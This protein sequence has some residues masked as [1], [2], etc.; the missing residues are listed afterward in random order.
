MLTR[1]PKQSLSNFEQ[2]KAARALAELV[3]RRNEGLRLY[4]SLPP[5]ERF[6]KS[7]AKIRM[8]IASN[9]GGKTVGAAA[10]V[11]RAFTATDPYNK[12]PKENGRAIIVAATQKKIADPLWLKL[13]RPGAFYI[14]RDE[15]TRN[16]RTWNPEN[17]YDA[18]YAEK[19]KEAAPLIPKRLI[20]NISYYSVKDDIPRHVVF[21]TGWEVFF[22]ADSAEPER[23]STY[24][25]G[26][27]DEEIS[28]R[29]WITEILRGLTDANGLFIWSA[30][31]QKGNVHAFE[32]YNRF[33]EGDP[34]VEVFEFFLRDNPYISAEGKREFEAS[35]STEEERLIRIEGHPAFEAYIIYPEFDP[36][37]HG[38]RQITVGNDWCR[39]AFI[40]P[41][42]QV[43]AVLF[44]AVPPPGVGKFVYAYDCLYIKQASASLFGEE[45]AKKVSG[46]AFEDFIIDSHGSRVT[47]IGS[48]RRV[49]DQYADEL[50]KRNIVCR[51]RGSGFGYGSTDVKG[52]ELA[53]REWLQLDGRGAPY[54]YYDRVKCAPLEKEIKYYHYKVDPRTEMPTDEPHRKNDHLIT[55]CQYGAAYRPTY[56]RPEPPAKTDPV[57]KFLE[58]RKRLLRRLTTGSKDYIDLG[59]TG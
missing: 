11:A 32:M 51:K 40:D 59:A 19:K 25:L 58:D 23:G 55:D 50:K 30:T 12:Y 8:L 18:A 7:R 33:K 26:W 28:K 36:A 22:N 3:R 5:A 38:G 49:E 39:F 17:Q 44:L 29:R 9:R 54:F 57:L 16:W 37:I 14:I 13:A 48:G 27:V 10:E 45:F 56:Y 41:G 24:N 2:L 15:Q 4:T 52:R 47:D 20:K 6:H 1:N 35:L 43:C 31:L 42:R 21:Q 34:S 46:L 53:F